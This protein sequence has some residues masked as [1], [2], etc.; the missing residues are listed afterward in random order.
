MSYINVAGLVSVM[1][2]F[3]F[4]FMLDPEF[5]AHGKSVSVDLPHVNHAKPMPKARAYD[6][7]TI[8]ITRDHK[9]FF[10]SDLI[11]PLQLTALINKGLSQG[12]ERKVYVQVDAHA[13]YVWVKDILD[14]IRDSGLENVAFL[15]ESSRNDLR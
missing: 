3:V 14:D 8:S 4:A 2:A 13:K 6:A 12:S 9:V 5:L 15:A 7:L 1:L 11:N 10:R